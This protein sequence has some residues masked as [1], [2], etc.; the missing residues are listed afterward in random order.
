MKRISLSTYTLRVLLGVALFAGITTA[1]ED[2]IDPRLEQAPS[3]LVVDAW[4]TNQERTQ[5]IKLSKTQSYFDNSRP[6]AVRNA[7]VLVTDNEGNSF[8]FT[9]RN[10][11]EY[12][13][14]PAQNG[15]LSFGRIGNQYRLFIQAEGKE[16]EAFSQMN[17]VPPIDSVTFYFEPANAFG[18]PDSWFS[19]YWVTDI[20][21]RGDTYWA[22]GWRN[23]QPLRR[24]N[25]IITAFDA[26]FSA[27]GN[28]DGIPFIAPLRRG[29]NPTETDADDNF[30]PVYMP[31]DS[32]YVE[33]H[34][35]TVQAF[36]FLTQLRIQTDRPG[37]FGELFAQPLANVPSNI[38]P[39]GSRD[40]VVG[41]FNT[42]A[43]SSNGARL[44]TGS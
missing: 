33:L 7:T 21:G 24:P 12:V 36:D 29:F 18:F 32:L 16:Y 25:E 20:P 8:P 30:L 19:E 23:G 42:A 40:K 1:C 41:F 3:V 11:G 22:Q 15:Q 39:I 2:T 9:E 10:P 35:I 43:V 34:S 17:R 31:G 4:I 27:G 28:V 38:R 37:G 5:V 6:P 26:G 44:R 14:D 13:W